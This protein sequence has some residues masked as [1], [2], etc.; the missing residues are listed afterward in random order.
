M[1]V[2]GKRNVKLLSNGVN[3][4]INDVYYILKLRNNLLSD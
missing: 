1:N 4:V 2:M 3:H